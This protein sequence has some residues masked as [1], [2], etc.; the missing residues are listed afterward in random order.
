MGEDKMLIDYLKTSIDR[1]ADKFE[2]FLQLQAE[3]DIRHH[4]LEYRVQDHTTRI[5]NLETPNQ[6]K[7]Q[8]RYPIVYKLCETIILIGLTVVVMKVMPSVGHVLTSTLG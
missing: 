4:E 2:L 7:L 6:K 8:E 1:L 3:R 5:V